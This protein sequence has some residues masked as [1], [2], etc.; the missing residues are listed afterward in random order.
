M[1]SL[2]DRSEGAKL[3]APSVPK[4]FEDTIFA[5]ESLKDV[6]QAA[7]SPRADYARER[8]ERERADRE[9]TDVQRAHRRVQEARDPRCNLFGRG[10]Y[11]RE[12]TE[13]YRRPSA[14]GEFVRWRDLDRLLRRIRETRG[15]VWTEEW[16]HHAME[17]VRAQT[18]SVV[19][20]G[21]RDRILPN[22]YQGPYNLTLTELH[23][24]M[25]VIA[26]YRFRSGG[27]YDCQST[28]AADFG[29]SERALRDALNGRTWTT[30]KGELRTKQGLVERGLVASWQTTRPGKDGRVNDH[31]WLLLRVGPELE[32]LLKSTMAAQRQVI[33]ATD[34][35]R[36]QAR[37]AQQRLRR[38]ARMVRYDRATRAWQI[39]RGWREDSVKIPLN[40]CA[41]HCADNPAP[42]YLKGEGGRLRVTGGEASASPLPP[43][44]HNTSSSP[45][46]PP[47]P[48]KQETVSLSKTQGSAAHSSIQTSNSLPDPKN[49]PRRGRQALDEVA[50]KQAA[51]TPNRAAK[52][53]SSLL[54][55][56]TTS[57]AGC[58][59]DTILRPGHQFSTCELAKWRRIRRGNEGPGVQRRIS[60][61]ADV[62]SALLAEDIRAAYSTSFAGEDS[63]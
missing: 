44:P 22:E 54:R 30:S 13:G 35:E 23:V 59:Q 14:G 50:P 53:S 11:K 28:L 45:T 17:D 57:V 6:P 58:A 2:S 1:T 3:C 8:A 48:E 10:V 5:Q 18:Y 42:P 51:S 27:V 38:E 19:E 61:P 29:L 63:S 31:H 26:A 33:D 62:A 49:L 52:A 9:A 41:A 20:L 60:I 15:N 7:D 21:S 34:E 40:N 56:Q 37:Y 43:T 25:A 39:R 12:S 4:F 46:P 32:P 16:S 47:L 24:L 55:Q 36:R